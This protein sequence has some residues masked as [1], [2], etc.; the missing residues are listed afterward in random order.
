VISGWDNG[1]VLVRHSDS[2]EVLFKDS[3]EGPVAGIVASDYRL[4]GTQ[5]LL[6]VSQGACVPVCRACLP[7]LCAEVLDGVCVCVCVC[8]C[9]CVCVCVAAGEVRGYVAVPAEAAAKQQDGDE[10]DQRVINELQQKKVCT[11][12]QR[13]VLCCAVLCGLVV[14]G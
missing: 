3:F 2:G 11:A 8:V 10:Q 13:L 4:T 5:D 9:M 14:L 6:V 1:A 12:Q 7:L